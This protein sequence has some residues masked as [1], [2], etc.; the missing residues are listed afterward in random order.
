MSVKKQ[1]LSFCKLSSFYG[2]IPEEFLD[3]TDVD[4]YF[5][6]NIF[7]ISQ[8]KHRI[9]RVTGGSNK[10]IVSNQ[11]LPFFRFEDPATIY[12][13]RRSEYLQKR[14]HLFGRQCAGF[15][16]NFWSRWQVYTDLLPKPKNEIGSTT[17]K[18]IYLLIAITTSLNIQKENLF[19][20]PIRK[21]Q[22]LRIFHQDV[23]T[24]LQSFYNY[25][26]CQ[27]KPSQNSPSLQE[28]ILRCKQEWTN[29]EQLRCVAHS[30]LIVGIT[31]APLFSLGTCVV[32]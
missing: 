7:D 21:Q 25:R 29:W 12:P 10:K 26:N 23:W 32:Q 20:V 30:P 28:P 5:H 1:N 9:L 3:E 27:S 22:V 6:H 18:T 14:T 16:Q 19:I 31:I 8:Y 15:S 4:S 2:E 11:S 17:S 13:P 24:T